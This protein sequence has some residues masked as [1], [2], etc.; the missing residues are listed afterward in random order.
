VRDAVRRHWPEYL[1]E[2]A[3]LGL[4]MAVACGVAVLAVHPES[5]L[6]RAVPNETLRRVLSGL[7]MG[8]TAVGLIYSPWGKRSGGHMNPAVTLAFHRLG[9]VRTPDAAWYA[10]AQFAG[11]VAGVAVALVAFGPRVA[12]PG[13][14]F[15]VTMPG[16]WGAG[17]A[18]VAELAISAVMMGTILAFANHPRR[19]NLTGLAAGALVATFISLEG[20]LS[21]MSM[22][23]A[24]TFGSA[25]WAGAWMAWWV[26]FTA[27]PIGMVLA[28]ALRQ[29]LDR[30]VAACAK[31]HHDNDQRCIFCGKPAL[32][33]VP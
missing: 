31:L 23:P 26:Y 4:F 27:P 29:R 33:R 19:A 21:G 3:L 12:D 13:V 6:V 20:P 28:A 7:A 5:P 8:G 30:P 25:V 14:R 15:A 16:P 22:N 9:K 1:M 10:L 18:F 11:A 24:R 17:V 32:R 2:A